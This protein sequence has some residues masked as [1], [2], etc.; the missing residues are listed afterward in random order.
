MGKPRCVPLNNSRFRVQISTKLVTN[1]THASCT[2][3]DLF[4]YRSEQPKTMDDSGTKSEKERLSVES[5]LEILGEA[6]LEPG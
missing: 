2:C 6:M 4:L 5:P 1:L 3:N